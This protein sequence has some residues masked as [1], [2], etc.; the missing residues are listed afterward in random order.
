MGGPPPGRPD[1]EPGP[2]AAQPPH[3]QDSS[4]LLLPFLR[5]ALA[6]QHALMPKLTIYRRESPGSRAHPALCSGT[7][8][9]PA[10]HRR[11]G[12]Q[13]NRRPGYFRKQLQFTAVFQKHQ[14][15]FVTKVEGRGALDT[16]YRALQNCGKA[17]RYPVLTGRARLP[18]FKDR[19]GQSAAPTS[20]RK[21]YARRP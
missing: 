10:G 4:T 21:K 17:F 9:I 12:S 5:Q 7:A 16:A 2:I 18:H 19:C 11:P 6:L 15:D 20:M 8:A 14:A 3:H 1:F 13:K